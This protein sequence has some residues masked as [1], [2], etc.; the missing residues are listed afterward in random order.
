Q[1]GRSP[2]QAC[3]ELDRGEQQRQ[4]RQEEVDWHVLA[5]NGE[6]G[7]KRVAGTERQ[8]EVAEGIGRHGECQEGEQEE[9][10]AALPGQTCLHRRW[11]SWR[12]ETMLGTWS[13][14]V[15][16]GRGIGRATGPDRPVRTCQGIVAGYLDA[17]GRCPP[18]SATGSRPGPVQV[19]YTDPPGP[20]GRDRRR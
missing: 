15:V 7:G 8:E 3:A 9:S 12:T 11:P 17:T 6:A 2:A 16:R 19:R 18:G 4:C 14:A 10:A 1:C 20:A 5:G 13:S